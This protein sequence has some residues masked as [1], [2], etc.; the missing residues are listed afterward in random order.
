MCRTIAPAM[1]QVKRSL[2]DGSLAPSTAGAF[3]LRLGDA[4]GTAASQLAPLDPPAFEG[5]REFAVAFVDTLSKASTE[6]KA[7]GSK[8]RATPE[9]DVPKVLMESWSTVPSAT[10]SMHQFSG[11]PELV[12]A[13]RAIPDCQPLLNG[14]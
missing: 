4:Y 12:S 6:L 2:T 1:T 14:G 11:V 7:V 3:F 5:G 8:L 10:K 9:D 13:A